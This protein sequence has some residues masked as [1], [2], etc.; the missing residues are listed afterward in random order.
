MTVRDNGDWKENQSES[1]AFR[2]AI[3]VSDAQK[4]IFRGFSATICTTILLWTAADL[5]HNVLLMDG[6]RDHGIFYYAPR[7]FLSGQDAYSWLAMKQAWKADGSPTGI[8]PGTTMSGFV[9]PPS[10]ALLYL[11]ASLMPPRFGYRSIDVLN[12]VALATVLVCL[13]QMVS[14]RWSL[15]AR[16]LF[17]A[18][19]LTLP[20]VAA[21]IALGQ[22]TLLIAACLSV[23]TLALNFGK[24]FERGGEIVANDSNQKEAIR[25]KREFTR[26]GLQIIGGAF[27]GIALSKFTITLPVIGILALQRRWRTTSVAVGTFAIVNLIFATPFGVLKTCAGFL[28][29]VAR[30]NRPGSSYD[31]IS[32]NATWMPNT[33]IHAK[34]MIFLTIGDHRSLVEGLNLGLTLLVVLTLFIAFRGRNKLLGKIELPPLALATAIATGLLIF[35]HRN[36]DLAVI[37]IILWALFDFGF[38]NKSNRTIV[39][40]LTLA[41]AVLLS[42]TPY[43][44]YQTL[45]AKI[46]GLD[47]PCLSTAVLVFVLFAGTAGLALIS[48]ERLGTR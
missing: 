43:N 46:G 27:I 37:P 32:R 34:R 29:A 1:H 2:K 35:Y 39:W 28:S 38:L 19:V 9:T 23:G 25:K 36:Y 17:S 8:D 47:A 4:K 10:M 41:S 13:M 3:G 22:S 16:L 33:L 18:Y 20:A 31:A 5:M 21:V 48:R 30:E 15:E 7:F 42:I 24:E 40:Y 26:S 6:W 12:L 44:F 14:K 45:L 11:P